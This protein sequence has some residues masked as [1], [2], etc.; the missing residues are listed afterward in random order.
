[1]PKLKPRTYLFILIAVVLFGTVFVFSNELI[2]PLG[3]LV[4]LNYLFVRSSLGATFMF[5]LLA[6]TGRVRSAFSFLKLRWKE[7]LF[8]TIA[9]HLVPLV[10]VFVASSYT[11]GANQVIIN[12][13]NLSFV[14]LINFLLYR[15]R[16]SKLAFV[17]VGINFAGAL[18]VLWPLDFSTNPNL[19]GDL[20]MVAGVFIGAFFPGYNKRIVNMDAGGGDPIALGFFLNFIPAL[21]LLPFMFVLQLWGP[22]AT[23][24]PLH[25]FYIAWIGLGVSGLA[26]TLG[27]AAYQD[28]NL[29]PQLYSTFTTLIPVIGLLLSVLVYSDEFGWV[30]IGGAAMIIASI[31]L[32]QNASYKKRPQAMAPPVTG[33]S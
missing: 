20:I 6:V 26:Y 16:P 28:E 10:I 29:T 3:P 14:V 5:A 15:E 17:A 11:T 32:A 18:L 2:V 24:T 23:M 21:C 8:F 27:N 19:L 4:S 30:N 1:M 31:L 33:V 25:W 13:L 22:L 12:N 7:V 9:F